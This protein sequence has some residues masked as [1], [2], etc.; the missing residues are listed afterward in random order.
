MAQVIHT[1][2]EYNQFFSNSFL[3]SGIE[4]INRNTSDIP[5][6]VLFYVFG[7]THPSLQNIK[8]FMIWKYGGFVFV[9]FCFF[10]LD[11][12][13][14][15]WS[16]VSK[17]DEHYAS[18][19]FMIL[20]YS[21]YFCCEIPLDKIIKSKNSS[22]ARNSMK[23]LYEKMLASLTLYSLY[24]GCPSLTFPDLYFLIVRV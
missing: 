18:V 21:Q 16:P 1:V 17:N 9:L 15:N 6:N 2:Y 8:I 12:F 23:N 7:N 13:G 19:V 4:V 3:N 24:F 22:P 5:N 20:S 11:F 10:L 14:W